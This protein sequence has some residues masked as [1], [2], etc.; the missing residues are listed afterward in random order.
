M[1]GQAFDLGLRP[2]HHRFQ[3]NDELF[4]NRVV[5][6]SKGVE[7]GCTGSV[8]N[9]EHGQ[10]LIVIRRHHELSA[11]GPACCNPLTQHVVG[12]AAQE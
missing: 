3:I 6:C 10:V 7:G 1:R 2:A 12:L 4:V 5:C 9:P 8:E 11:R